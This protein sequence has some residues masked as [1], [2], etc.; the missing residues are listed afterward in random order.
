MVMRLFR[1]ANASKETAP[2]FEDDS[3]MT[4]AEKCASEIII[5]TSRLAHVLA[6]EADLLDEMKVAQIAVLQ[7]EK[8]K[9]TNAL[10]AIKKQ[11]NKH[12]EW[13]K[14]ISDEQREDIFEVI[15]VFNII[16]EENYQRL[17]MARLVNQKVIEA[18]SD[19]VCETAKNDLYDHKGLSN[20]H[21]VEP[22]SLT[23]NEQA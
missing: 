9:L 14:E 13:M 8:V 16:L 12:P 6:V 11:I 19:V 1:N 2:I 15:S 17:T 18:I 7:D 4:D 5:L 23:I 21:P 10:E 20:Q 22:I 3:D